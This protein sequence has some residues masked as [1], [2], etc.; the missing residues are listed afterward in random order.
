[1]L[2]KNRKIL[3][4][5]GVPFVLGF[6]L[7]SLAGWRYH[8]SRRPLHGGVI[9]V[10]PI[11]RTSASPR[12]PVLRIESVVQHGHFMEIRGAA[13]PGTTVMINGEKAELIFDHSSFKHFLGPLPLGSTIITITAQN[14]EGGVNTQQVEVTIH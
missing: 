12:T 13:E 8:L 1:M 14:K 6:L 3:T 10:Q 4:R 11:S 9:A 2:L 5:F 7:I